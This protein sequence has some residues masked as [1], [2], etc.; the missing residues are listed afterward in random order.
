VRRLRLAEW[1]CALALAPGPARA[2]LSDEIQVYDDG[3]NAPRVFGLELHANATPSGRSAPDYPGEVTPNHGLRLTP[4]FSCGLTEAWEAGLYV[5]TNRDASGNVSLAG[6]K[7]RLKWLPVHGAEGE[8]GWFAGANG[9]LSRLEQKFSSSRDSFELRVMGGYR[10]QE[11]LLAVNPVFGW[12]LSSGYRS[13]T[14]D[15]SLGIKA[16]R[17][18][19]AGIAL[20]GEYYS[21]LGTTSRILPLNAQANTLYAVVDVDL[22]GWG[23]NFGIGRGLTGS[24]DRY[25][26]KAIFEIPL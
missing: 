12:S 16:T 1:L 19:A 7:L 8:G 22:K 4:E 25:T 24:A 23:F 11:W 10:A 13:S 9:E 5:P 6:W 20:G 15:F 2:A 17:K 18:I 14:P 3:I 26:V 21:E